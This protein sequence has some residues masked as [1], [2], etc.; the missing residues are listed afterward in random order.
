MLFE[1]HYVAPIFPGS[2][3]TTGPSILNFSY[4]KQPPD[5]PWKFSPLC[6]AHLV[7]LNTC[8]YTEPTSNVKVESHAFQSPPVLPSTETSSF[9]VS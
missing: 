1:I 8:P 6:F 9:S 5:I 2:S 7:P 3:V 4:G